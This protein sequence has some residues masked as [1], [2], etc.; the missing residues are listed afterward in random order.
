MAAVVGPA[1][2]ALRAGSQH[3][4]ILVALLYGPAG[5]L[6]SCD[7]ADAP[8][9]IGPNAGCHALCLHHLDSLILRRFW[10][11]PVVH[12]YTWL[13]VCQPHGSLACSPFSIRGSACKLRK[14]QSTHI[15][16]SLFMCH[17]WR[18]LSLA[19]GSA[20]GAFSHPVNAVQRHLCTSP[21]KLWEAQ[22]PWAEPVMVA[23]RA[24][25]ANSSW[26]A[27]QCANNATGFG[28]WLGFWLR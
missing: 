5:H 19:A 7:S 24:S 16:T 10:G 6:L 11:P 8:C 2:S 9:L 21:E 26:M 20:R 23:A 12:V 17:L 1:V 13:E 3:C 22:G 15:I 4:D 14:T 25:A 28:Q 18:A 27:C